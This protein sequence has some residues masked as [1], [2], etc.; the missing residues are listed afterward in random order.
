MV[1]A[2]PADALGPHAHR[3][4]PLLI[5]TARFRHDRSA[6]AHEVSESR[7]ATGFGAQWR[8][9]QDDARTALKNLGYQTYPLP[10][11][12]YQLSVVND[13]LVY[14]WRVPGHVDNISAFASSPTRKT[15]SR[16]SRR[17]Q[18]SSGRSFPANPHRSTT[19][20]SRPTSR[21]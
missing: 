16:P 18:R 5:E 6:D 7:Y 2:S 12:G 19:C 1:P 8:D 13:C 11:A 4:R 3:I 15:L 20:W 9:L 17:I 10:P 14:V 21:A